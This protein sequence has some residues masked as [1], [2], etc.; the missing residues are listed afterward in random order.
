MFVMRNLDAIWDVL[1][2]YSLDAYYTIL[3]LV[4]LFE[5]S[6]FHNQVWEQAHFLHNNFF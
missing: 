5:K 1:Y 6:F 2:F 3:T 4:I